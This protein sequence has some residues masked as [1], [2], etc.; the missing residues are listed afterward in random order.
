MTYKEFFS[1]FSIC[2]TIYAFLPYAQSIRKEL[3][4]PH[5][6]SWIIWTITTCIIFIAQLSDNAGVGAW[7]IGFSG[8]ASAYIALLAY[9]HK[10]DNSITR[11]DWYFFITAL[12]SLPLWAITSDPLWA[13]AILT[14]I[15]II[16]FAPTIRKT[17]NNP[18]EEKLSFFVLIA[19]RNMLSIIAL[20]H[21][22]L[23]TAL[24]PA[25][26]S[27]ACLALIMTAIIQRKIQPSKN[28]L[29]HRHENR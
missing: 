4:K 22:S 13:V 9:N 15:D 6:F 24:F 2:I 1:I 25:A 20:E 16:G 18:Y 21:Y 17:Y 10:S 8:L 29:T 14:L 27:I 19:I 28:S 3:V 12:L 26:L 7:P 23:V 5:L 11:S